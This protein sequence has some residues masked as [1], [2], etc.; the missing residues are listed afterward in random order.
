MRIYLRSDVEAGKIMR[1]RGLGDNGK[2]VKFMADEVKRL[3][4]PYVPFQQGSLKNG[5]KIA[6]GGKRLIYQRPYAHYQYTGQAMSGRAPKHYNGKSLSYNGAP[7][8]GDHW[9]KRMMAD[10]GE[11]LERSTENYIRSL[12]K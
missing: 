12:A 3:C 9:E 6:D 1:N 10:H 2:V 8:R 5:A 7:M 4:D 11:E